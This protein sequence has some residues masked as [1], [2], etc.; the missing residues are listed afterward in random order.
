MV[1]PIFLGEKNDEKTRIAE[2]NFMTL[3]DGDKCFDNCGTR[4]LNAGIFEV[5]STVCEH[6]RVLVIGTI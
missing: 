3:E 4:V 2:P 5:I 1:C 6:F